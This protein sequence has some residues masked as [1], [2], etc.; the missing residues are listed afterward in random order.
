MTPQLATLI[1]IAGIAALFFLDRDKGARVSGWLW[2]PL[3]WL[4]IVGSRPVSTWF[5]AGPTIAQSDQNLD[6]SPADAAVFGVLVLAGIVV[7][8][9]RSRK[10]KSFLRANW[11]IL[12][13]FAYCAISIAWSDYS[14][15]AFKRWIKA[16]GDVIM[17]LIVLTDP[18]PAIATKRFFS[19][20]S[21]LLLPISMLL[22]KYYPTLGRTYNQWTWTPMYTGVTTFKNLLGM[23][24]LV[25]GLGSLWSFMGAYLDKQLPHRFRHMIAHGAM[26]VMAIW[27]IH[28]ADSMT[29]LAC[30]LM[31]GALL[32]IPLQKR[33][34]TRS[35]VAQCLIWGAISLSIFN[36]F[37]GSG[38]ILQS[39]GRD[40]TLTGRTDIWK[41]VLAM[42]TNPVIGTGYES[43]W[44]GSRLQQVDQMTEKG[45]QEAHDGYL[46]VYLNLGYAGIAL[47]AGIIILGYRNAF[48]LFKRDPQA[49]RLRLAFFTAGVIYSF[50]EAGF[51][52]L[53][54]IWVGFLLAATCIPIEKV[55]RPE[56]Q[57]AKS[58]FENEAEKALEP[59]GA[60]M[61]GST[62]EEHVAPAR[63]VRSASVSRFTH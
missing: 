35:I 30:L 57:A 34:R 54:P 33:H 38:T 29:S 40:P 46:E 56:R 44:M 23:T 28:T 26:V 2:I 50:T 25:C 62:I 58:P 21:F 49:G 16:I 9:S 20:A 6:G 1:Y 19:R 32:W 59:A 17:V 36:L 7:L 14:F 61:I 51:R 41:A 53:T 60:L 48:A 4:L 3:L 18:D 37:I 47:L 43:F 15:I 42:H 12:L 39:L 45:I 63:S 10:V 13:F 55:R 27:L 11:P 24:A 31:A 52:M 8:V 22:I 5:Q